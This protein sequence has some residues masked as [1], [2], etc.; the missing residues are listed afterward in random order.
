MD[1]FADRE[2]GIIPPDHVN[3]SYRPGTYH[4]KSHEHHSMHISRN[5]HSKM[6]AGESGESKALAS[7]AHSL[8]DKA[9]AVKHTIENHAAIASAHTAAKEAHAKAAEHFNNLSHEHGGSRWAIDRSGT[10]KEPSG[11]QGSHKVFNSDVSKHYG[12][13]ARYHQNAHDYHAHKALSATE[14]AP[15]YQSAM[16]TFNSTKNAV[17]KKGARTKA[18]FHKDQFDRN[19]EHKSLKSYIDHAGQINS[20]Y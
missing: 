1:S 5:D 7:A 12:Q 15:K 6:I 13:L 3:P 11:H 9:D 2:M 16:K 4:T 18:Q 8:S 19:A 10:W 14:Y 20:M 17:V